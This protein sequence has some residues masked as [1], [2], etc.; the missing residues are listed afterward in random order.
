MSKQ[1]QKIIDVRLNRY[2]QFSSNDIKKIFRYVDSNLEKKLVGNKYVRKERQ[3]NYRRYDMGYGDKG[4]TIEVKTLKYYRFGDNIDIEF[5]F[6]RDEWS[7]FSRT[8]S[9]KNP[10]RIKEICEEMVDA[11]NEYASEKL[12]EIEQE[13]TKTLQAKQKIEELGV[14]LNC[15]RFNHDSNDATVLLGKKRI[16]L[17]KN[18][19]GNKNCSSIE[20]VYVKKD[21]VEKVLQAIKNLNLTEVRQDK[22]SD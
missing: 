1:E 15:P 21:E 13:E 4:V 11:F 3:Q 18:S 10:N 6:Y 20:I 22:V 2:K 8:L 5:R 16:D 19:F 14:K 12:K 9:A 17:R 7:K